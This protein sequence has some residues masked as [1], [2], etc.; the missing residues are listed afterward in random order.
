MVLLPFKHSAFGLSQLGS[1]CILVLMNV[2]RLGIDPDQVK[3]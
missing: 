2:D 3:W 1:G